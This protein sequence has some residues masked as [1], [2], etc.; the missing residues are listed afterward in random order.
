MIFFRVLGPL[1]AL[2][3]ERDVTSTAR[4]SIHVYVARLRETF[5]DDVIA[6]TGGGYRL[7]RGRSRVDLA[8]LDAA[9]A[10]ADTAEATGDVASAVHALRAGLDMW[11][12]ERWPMCRLLH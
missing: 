11:R 10:E 6:T 12:G 7:A 1:Q 2:R 5:G 4:K 9:V 8:A 3:D